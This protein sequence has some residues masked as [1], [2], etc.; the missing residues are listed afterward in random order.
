MIPGLLREEARRFFRRDR[1]TA[2]R[3][4]F[5][6][7][8]RRHPTSA[9]AHAHLGFFCVKE[10][11]FDT[12]RGL[13]EFAVALG[14]DPVCASAYVY[15]AITL[16]SL[17]RRAEA[18]AALA[19]A[20]KLDAPPADMTLARGSVE[21]EAGSVES[22]VVHFQ[23]LV[24]LE[25]DSTNMLLLTQ[26]HL[27]ARRHEEALSWAREAAN[28]EPD[29]FRAPVYGAI[30]LAYLE[31]F[32][33]ARAELCRAAALDADYALLHHTRAYVALKTGSPKEAEAH[34]RACLRCDP[35][36]VTSR[37]LLADLCAGSGRH[38]EA[39]AHYQTALLL[40]P[41][42]TEAREALQRLS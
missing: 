22:A 38:E 3:I 23:A 17:L 33:E 14:L 1:W 5:E 19:A 25:K 27:Q 29:D 35:N 26:A 40:F 24:E 39:R 8:V 18:D 6:E 13:A 10:S 16:G 34:A 11:R 15:R 4:Y 2:G 41:D 7:A 42:Y 36:Y 12:A 37:K 30:A 9:D 21:L 31:R 32:E 28:A 20:E